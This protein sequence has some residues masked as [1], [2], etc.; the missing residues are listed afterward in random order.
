M[1]AE[2]TEPAERFLGRL[3]VFHGRGLGD[4]AG[5]QRRMDAVLPQCVRNAIR[6]VVLPHLMSRQVD[7]HAHAQPAI[8]PLPTLPARIRDDPVADR[9][10]QAEALRHG[11][12]HTGQHQ[13][14]GR[15]LP[16]QQR[17]RGRHQAGLRVDFRLVEQLEL[18]A[19]QRQPQVSQELER[20][21]G[22]GI[23]RG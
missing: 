15:M 12:E 1:G 2:V 22:V 9:P 23:Q 11:N 6:N 20:L 13:A 8:A 5:Q 18:V 14:T 4:L 17:L 3:G 16:A 7:R 21:L 10:D 19:C